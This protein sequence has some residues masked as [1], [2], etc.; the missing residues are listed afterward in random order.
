MTCCF[1]GT[2]EL[3]AD[4]HTP[5]VLKPPCQTSMRT[6][7]LGGTRERWGPGGGNAPPPLLDTH[8]AG[9]QHPGQHGPRGACPW[10]LRTAGT[11]P[12]L[13]STWDSAS[14]A[15]SGP[16]RGPRGRRWGRGP[17]G[18]PKGKQA[19]VGRARRP[20]LTL[21]CRQSSVS[22]G[23]SLTFLPTPDRREPP[24]Y[25]APW[26]LAPGQSP[27][28]ALALPGSPPGRGWSFLLPPP[29]TAPG[30]SQYS[31]WCPK[32]KQCPSVFSELHA[33]PGSG[34]SQ[35]LPGEMSRCCCAEP[36]HQVAP[37]ACPPGQG[38]SSRSHKRQQ[39]VACAQP[40]GPAQP[41]A[42]SRDLGTGRGQMGPHPAAGS[43]APS[44][45]GPDCSWWQ[46]Q[47]GTRRQ[48]RKRGTE[49]TCFNALGRILHRTETHDPSLL[50]VV[51]NERF[52]AGLV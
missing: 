34:R 47:L 30:P 14:L 1:G 15:C 27:R 2:S 18:L 5:Q 25:P 35:D 13:W 32:S 40:G 49:N 21:G 48:E 8:P 51:K 46:G 6:P 39:V 50:Q 16:S 24:P 26:A 23:Q 28:P 7:G 11:G 38:R 41:L 43:A 52:I 33:P 19:Q 10:A 22:A 17:V 36:P 9:S 3:S 42:P 45:L 44:R 29:I 20:L 37:L 31:T 12:L 4:G